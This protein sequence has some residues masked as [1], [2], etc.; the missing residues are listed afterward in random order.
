M[1]N[2]S[3]SFPNMERQNI[4]ELIFTAVVITALLGQTTIQYRVIVY[5]VLSLQHQYVGYFSK[6][7]P[8]S[9]DFSLWHFIGK[10]PDVEN[11]GGRRFIQTLFLTVTAI[12]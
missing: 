11:S 5:L 7:E 9:D 2:F 1:V 10:F 12:R 3:L 6:G 8:Q 4:I